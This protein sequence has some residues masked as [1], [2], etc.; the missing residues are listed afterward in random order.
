MKTPEGVFASS[1]AEGARARRR[2]LPSFTLVELL[3]SLSILA[4]I[5]ALS[6]GSFQ[7]ISRVV[8]VN[9]R[10]ER[11]QRSVRALV[12]RLDAE[13][14]GAIF[15]RSEAETLFLSKRG[16]ID[17]KTFNDLSF[18][19]LMPQVYLEIGKRDEI[20]KVE[21]TVERNEGNEGLLVVRKRI[22]TSLLSPFPEREPEPGPETG[23][24]EFVVRDDFTV[25]EMRF[26]K[27]GR[28][29]E[30]W[31][32]KQMSLAPDGVELVFSLGDKTFREY[33]NVFI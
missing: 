23:V 10:N 24:A 19:T 33:F 5:A 1:N 18:T 7:S 2:G 27:G 26:Y 11:A 21:Y 12:D 9:R 14:A 29:Y 4:V 17:G 32:S 6:F 20:V 30:S 3:V 8:D 28:W 15:A 13:L 25:F 16:E 22:Y 31:D